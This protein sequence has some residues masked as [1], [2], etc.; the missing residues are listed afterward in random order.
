MIDTV[1]SPNHSETDRISVGKEHIPLLD[2][3]GEGRFSLA[4][5]LN[6][7]PIKTLGPEKGQPIARRLHAHAL[8]RGGPVSALAP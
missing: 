2:V 5:N 7:M 6:P 8:S 4:V 3:G 1:I